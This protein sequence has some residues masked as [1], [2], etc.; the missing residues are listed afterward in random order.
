MVELAIGLKRR[1]LQVRVAVFYAVGPFAAKLRDAG[2]DIIDLRKSGRW[3]LAGF[4]LRAIFAFRR[5]RPDII[6]S[7]LGGGNIVAAVARLFTPSARLIWS[8]RSS[9]FDSS[10]DLWLA[11]VGYRLEAALAGWPDAIISNSS[12]GRSFAIERGFP[13]ARIRIVPNGVDCERFRPDPTAREEQRRTLRLDDDHVAI[14]V[15]ARLNATKG[16]PDFLRAAALVADAEPNARFLCIGSGEDR[17]ELARL[18]L[19]LG[20]NERVTFTGELDAARALNALDIACSPSIEEAFSNAIVEAMACGVPCVVTDV[21]D[22][23]V[24]VGDA[25][26]VVP[27]SSPEMLAAALVAQIRDLGNHDPATPR[28][29]ILDNFSADAMVDRTLEVFRSVLA[30]NPASPAP[31]P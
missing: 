4:L 27:A 20:I 11:R 29:R 10:I 5:I 7:F 16:Y 23:A 21:G 12:A 8:V 24:I 28:Q 22:S 25:G 19:E 2:I 3:D 17:D 30:A 15:L 13:A 31:S 26:T 18:A 1:G 9:K 6:Y 14:G